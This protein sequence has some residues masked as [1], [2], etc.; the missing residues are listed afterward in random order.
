[1]E[2]KEAEYINTNDD[3]VEI[4]DAQER[5]KLKHLKNWQSSRSAVAVMKNTKDYHMH[6][7]TLSD[8]KA[9]IVIAAASIIISVCIS[10]LSQYD[11]I[12]HI[13]LV[14]I[15]ISTGIALLCAILSVAPLLKKAKKVLSTKDPDFNPLFFG[16]Y[17]DVPLDEYTPHMIE[18][19]QDQDK[20]YQE[21]IKDL[22]QMGQVLK[23][24]KFKYLSWSYRIFF[25]GILSGL[26]LSV[27][28]IIIA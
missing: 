1:M 25:L 14:V 28:S 7:T 2:S 18:I 6:L 24:R 20:M 22:Y 17:T 21:M 26:I 9:S 15:V 13:A 27:L 16:H 11:G 12:L 3:L 10:Q 23:Q 5:Q 4:E 19:L 8:Q